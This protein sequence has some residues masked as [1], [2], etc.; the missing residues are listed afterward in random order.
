MTEER[1]AGV[2]QGEPVGIAGYVSPYPYVDR[3]QEK[4]E[5]RLARRVPASGR[6]CGFCYARL[7]AEDTVC[8]F[9]GTATAEREP[10][11][12]I[13][14]EVLRLYLAKQKTEARWVHGGAFF[15]LVVASALFIWMVIWGP[16]ILG[17]PALAFGVLLLGGYVLA[18]LFG[19]FIGAQIGYRKGARR[20]DAMWAEFLA[21]R[22]GAG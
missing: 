10:V 2:P 8:P 15:G 18:Q 12:E 3:L 4:M 1:A 9:C 6:F 5:E 7:R 22:D 11:S 21:R 17:H 19:T 16:G 14:Q 20:R 13:P